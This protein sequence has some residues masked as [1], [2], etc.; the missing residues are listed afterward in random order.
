MAANIG[1]EGPIDHGKAAAAMTLLVTGG[2]GFIGSAVVLQAL[3]AGRKVV[4]LDKLTYAANPETVSTLAA[5]PAHSLERADIA[6]AEAVAAILARHQ[7]Q[8]ILH[9]AAETHVDRSIDRP[10]EFI[11]TNIQGSF[12]LLQQALAYWTSL[13]GAAK[14]AFRFIHVSTDEVFGSLGTDGYFSEA[15]AYAPNSPYA[16]SKAASDHL[17]RAWHVTFG[18]PVVI[19]NCS[20][21]YGPRQFPEKLIPLMILN[22]LAGQSLPV[23]GDGQNVRDWLFVEDHA[24][25]LLTIADH[26]QAGGRYMIGGG[27][28]RGNLELVEM[29]C[30]LLDEARPDSPNRP[31]RRLIRFVADRPGHDRRYAADFSRITRELGWRP[32][33]DLAEGLR[34]TLAWYLNNPEWAASCGEAARARQGSDYSDGESP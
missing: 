23:Y 22:G 20:N 21:N 14:A 6:D 3:G 13:Q 32:R 9:L 2:A 29:L 11:A 16:A 1:A 10:G 15:S 30:D 5:Y 25:A 33:L 31:H 28:E 19:T 24:D 18:L 4:S 12:V 34:R 17:A 26:A 27:T 8:T 7:P